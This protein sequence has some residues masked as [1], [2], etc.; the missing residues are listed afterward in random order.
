MGTTSASPPSQ[1][2][3]SLKRSEEEDR[4]APLWGQSVA[5]LGSLGSEGGRGWGFYMEHLTV[6][7]VTLLLTLMAYRGCWMLQGIR[8]IDHKV[9]F[10]DDLG[11]Y[12]AS[13][14]LFSTR[15]KGLPPDTG[16]K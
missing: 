9:I 8:R 11:N 15:L 5:E 16:W 10:P 1:A 14:S 2:F 3:C 12:S 6:A 13:S 7:L 4:T